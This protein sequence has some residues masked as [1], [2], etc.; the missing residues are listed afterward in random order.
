MLLI[1]STFTGYQ[2]KPCSIFSAY[3]AE[4][5]ILVVSAETDFRR[6]RRKGCA[7]ITNDAQLQERDSLFTDGDI[8]EAIG[9]Y[10]ALRG[11]RAADDSSA[12]L[13][14]KDAVQRHDPS[15]A[16]ERDGIT[17]SGPKYRI[18]DAI[19]CGQMAVLAS[20]WYVETFGQTVDKVLNAADLLIRIQR[21]EVVSI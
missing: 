10:Y 4:S 9:V 5:G 21:G 6:K 8:S 19:S 1:Q 14:F 18:L 17:E 11:G 13:V 2:G 3:D 20:C 7:V 12:R 16:I 15:G